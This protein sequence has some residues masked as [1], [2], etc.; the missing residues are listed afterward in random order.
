MTQKQDL[1][2][3]TRRERIA[4]VIAGGLASN[5]E[6]TPEIIADFAIR[7]ADALMDRLDGKHGES[8]I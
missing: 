1:A 6:I 2:R 8:G 4:T 5:A 7:T 3:Q